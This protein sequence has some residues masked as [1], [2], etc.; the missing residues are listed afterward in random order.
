MTTRTLGP[1][2]LK[3]GETATIREWGG[4][5]AKVAL[6]PS[7]SGDDPVP[8]LDG[9]NLE[10]EDVTT[11]ELTG[12]IPDSFEFDSLQVFCIANQGKLLPFAWTPNDA[13]T[14]DY[15]GIVKIR[16]IAIGG[17][18]KKKN[19]NDFAFPVSGQPTPG[20]VV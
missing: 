1:G 12:T 4:E 15:S 3:I 9:S 17:D 2:S 5:C 6:E 7:T 14:V 8:M 11:W 18:V 10:S 13:G 20:E 16:P 19:Q